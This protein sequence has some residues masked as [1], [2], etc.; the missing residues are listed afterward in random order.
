MCTSNTMN[1]FC[2]FTIEM[3]SFMSISN[4]AI[5]LSKSTFYWLSNFNKLMMA[6]DSDVSTFQLFDV[7][8]FQFFDV[9]TF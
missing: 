7:S 3:I 6:I 8:T 5:H 1:I 4:R 9:S 2:T